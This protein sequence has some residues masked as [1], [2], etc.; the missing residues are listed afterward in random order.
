[1]FFKRVSKNNMKVEDGF[2]IDFT[3]MQV[4]FINTEDKQK[5]IYLSADLSKEKNVEIYRKLENLDQ[6]IETFLSRSGES[7]YTKSVIQ[8]DYIKVKLL[9]SQNLSGVKEGDIIEN[10][11]IDLFNIYIIK[12]TSRLKKDYLISGCIFHLKSFS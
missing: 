5:Y 7:V 9:K 12:R 3:E 2:S 8:N 1:M 6:E 11:N 4:K 10:V